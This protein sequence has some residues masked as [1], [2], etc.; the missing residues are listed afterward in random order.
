MALF[1]LPAIAVL[2]VDA[3][4]LE[5]ASYP[6]RNQLGRRGLTWHGPLGCPAL[7]SV[8]DTAPQVALQAGA[9]LPQSTGAPG[10]GGRPQLQGPRLSPAALRVKNTLGGLEPRLGLGPHM[11]A[12]NIVL[13]WRVRA[14]GAWGRGRVG[15]LTQCDLSV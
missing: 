9:G 14:P 2:E 1:S 6:Y 13:G 12:A 3:T 8:F 5:A 10:A 7:Q 11:R 15:G 4:C